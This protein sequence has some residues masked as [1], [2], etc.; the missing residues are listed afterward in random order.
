MDVPMG[1]AGSRTAASLD[2]GNG[3]T[4]MG[5]NKATESDL[6]L[7]V[8]P[9]LFM[10]GQWKRVDDGTSKDG[11]WRDPL[12]E[13]NRTHLMDGNGQLLYKEP[14]WHLLRDQNGYGLCD[15]DGNLCFEQ[16]DEDELTLMMQSIPRRAP[17]MAAHMDSVTEQ[18]QQLRMEL[19]QSLLAH[20]TDA[21]SAKEVTKQKDAQVQSDFRA[22]RVEFEKRQVEL[23]EKAHADKE[24][25]DAALCEQQRERN[26]ALCEQKES[27]AKWEAFVQQLQDDQVKH[28]KEVEDDYMHCIAKFDK[29]HV[30]HNE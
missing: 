17:V 8:S 23:A 21:E 7:S 11:D 3:V 18:N 4:H 19:D 6:A 15:D 10:H 5:M 30:Q 14:G 12:L 25:S 26:M 9:V 29:Q 24:R 27:D 28:Q 20:W 1:T 22:M 16:V 2:G 13:G